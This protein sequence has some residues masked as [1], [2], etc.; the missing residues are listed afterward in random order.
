[1]EFLVLFNSWNNVMIK[2]NLDPKLINCLINVP[3][4][5]V[6]AIDINGDCTEKDPN[7]GCAIQIG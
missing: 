7:G 1:M 2:K 4:P 6:C 3:N 5:G